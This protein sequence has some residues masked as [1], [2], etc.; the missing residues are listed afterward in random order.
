[1]REEAEERSEREIEREIERE[2]ERVGDKKEKEKSWKG[3]LWRTE[4]GREGS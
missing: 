4:G 2:K 1:V 3:R